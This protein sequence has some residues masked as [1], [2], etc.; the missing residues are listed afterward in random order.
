[1][2]AAEHYRH[3]IVDAELKVRLI[4]CD[5]RRRHSIQEPP[6]GRFQLFDTAGHFVHAEQP[7]AYAR[8]ITDFILS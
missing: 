4:S 5:V 2:D 3:E 8:L 6:N 1:M 7:E